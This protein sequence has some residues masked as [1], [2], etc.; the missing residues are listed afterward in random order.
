MPPAYSVVVGVEGAFEGGAA[1][2]QLL[3]SDEH[4]DEAL[5]VLER[6]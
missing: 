5:M 3:V 4:V 2:V 1:G 6:S